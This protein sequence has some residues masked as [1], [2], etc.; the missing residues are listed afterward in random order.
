M[1]FLRLFLIQLFGI[2]DFFLP[3]GLSLN[4]HIFS[5]HFNLLWHLILILSGALFHEDGAAARRWR[6]ALAAFS[7]Y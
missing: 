4:I 5:D 7:L 3:F 2:A 6:K 1:Y